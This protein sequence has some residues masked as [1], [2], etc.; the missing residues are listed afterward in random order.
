[1]VEKNDEAITEY[2]Y[3]LKIRAVRLGEEN[4][5]IKVSIIDSAEVNTFQA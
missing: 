3:N 5:L 2:K 4:K 1:M